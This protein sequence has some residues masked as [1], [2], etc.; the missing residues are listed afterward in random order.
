MSSVN[1]QTGSNFAEGKAILNPVIQ[2]II[3]QAEAQ[4]GLEDQ[5]T[6]LGFVMGDALTPEGEITSMVGPEE[7]EEMEEDGVASLVTTM[8]GWTKKYQLKEYGRKSKC[9]KIFS[10]WIENG[11][12]ME[13]ADTTVKL[14]LYK[15]KENVERLVQ[16]AILTRNRV[17]TEVL[18]NG[19]SVT[20]AYGPGS[21]TGDGVALFSASHVVKKTGATFSNLCTG[22]LSA[23]TLESTIQLY[24]TSV[25]TMNGYRV[26]TPE[27]FDLMVPR[28]LETTARKILNSNGDQAG[29]Y[30]GTANNANLL[31]VFSFQGSK[32]RLTVIDML[33][34]V[35]N[36]GTKIGGTNADAMWFLANTEYNLRYKAF[37][38]FQLWDKELN[39]WKEDETDSIYT[40]ITSYFTA[41]AYNFEGIMGYAGA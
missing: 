21:A 33:G 9:T 10:K 13:G 1:F 17:M 6:K 24:K 30:A 18:A 19:F 8:Q 29:I 3:S 39:M 15:F 34:E 28:A 2:E 12:Q 41:D 22:A 5:M 37:R 40:K 7:L 36:D 32:V 26:K 23:T 20:A 31:N 16:G 38:V 4:V 25:Y 27:I 35:K 14:E 11:A